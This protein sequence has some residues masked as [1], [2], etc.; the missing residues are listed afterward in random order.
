MDRL[1]G[2][3]RFLTAVALAFSLE[4]PAAQAGGG[5]GADGRILA[6]SDLLA[7][8]GPNAVIEDFETFDIAPDTAS[9]FD[10]I[11]CLDSTS[12]ADGQGPGLVRPGAAYCSPT[13][14]RICWNGDQY[15]Q[16]TTKTIEAGNSQAIHIVYTQFVTAMG[17]DLSAFVGFPYE[18]TATFYDTFGGVLGAVT[19]GVL[20]PSRS[21]LGWANAGGIGRVEI[22]SPSYFWSPK[23]D[24]HAFG[25]CGSVGDTFCPGNGS[26]APCPCGNNGTFGCEN[27]ASTGG[28]V[29]GASGNASVVSDTVVLTSA[30]ELPSALTIFLSGPTEIPPTNFGDGLRCTGG[31]L[32]RLYVKNAV[33]GIARAP[34]QGDPSITARMAALGAPVHAGESHHYQAYYRDP[35]EGF[36]PAQRFN[37][38]SGVRIQ[39]T[40]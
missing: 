17:V 28:A 34:T 38:S 10:N 40:P 37:I 14:P 6:R 24:D 21:F 11:T 20:G 25:A 31:Q 2:I 8:L 15:F 26:A 27:S 9:C 39:W 3:A 23:I 5:C 1:Q 29:L 13:G 16:R 4:A 12:V 19:F 18:G 36:C 22:Y 35:V 7:R 32:R 33:N 30:G